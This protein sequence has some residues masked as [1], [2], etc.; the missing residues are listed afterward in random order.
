MYK[1]YLSISIQT[2]YWCYLLLIFVTQSRYSLY[3]NHL[4]FI[5]HPDH[6]LY[7]IISSMRNQRGIV[8]LIKFTQAATC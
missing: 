3:Y 7:K 1:A 2:E 6:L 8:E 4:V 5:Y